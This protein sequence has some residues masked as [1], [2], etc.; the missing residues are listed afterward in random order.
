MCQA[1]L[2]KHRPSFPSSQEQNTPLRY[3]K[4]QPWLK[5]PYCFCIS[6][7]SQPWTWANTEDL[8]QWHATGKHLQRLNG[9]RLQPEHSR[10]ISAHLMEA[11]S[12]KAVGSL[13]TPTA[14]LEHCP[15]HIPHP[16]KS[17][18]CPPHLLPTEC[19]MRG[20]GPPLLRK[21]RFTLCQQFCWCH[22]TRD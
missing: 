3:Q 4:N 16:Y 12:T 18:D 20:T 9:P 17:S 8:L 15:N 14:F 11:V 21:C 7:P 10:Y 22:R 1:S 6:C 13:S 2:V 5:N 19:S